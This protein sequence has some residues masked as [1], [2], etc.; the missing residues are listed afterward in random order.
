MATRSQLDSSTLK[1]LSP[2]AWIWDGGIGYRRDGRGDGG[3][4]YIKYRAPAPGTYSAQAVV[5]TRQI[6]ER[7]PNCK[8]KSQ[9][10]GVLMAR[11]AAIFEGTYQARKKIEPTTLAG[12][13][14]RFLETKRHLRTIRKYR[15]QIGQYLIPHFGK[16][17]L[18]AITSRDCNDYYNRRLDTKAAVSTVNGEMACLKSLFSEAMRNG[19]TTAN[20]VKGIKLLNPNNIRD[21]ILSNEETA[22]LFVAAASFDDFVRPLFHILF[23]TGMRLGEA[24][25]LQWA[26]IQFDLERIIIRTSKS[27]EGRRIPLRPSL[28]GE[29]IAWRPRAD[30]PQWLFPNRDRK[31]APMAAVRKGWIRLC[32]A[33]EIENLRPHDLRHNFTSQLQ[34]AGVSDSIIMSITGHKTHVMLLRYSHANDEHKRKALGCLYEPQEQSAVGVT[35]LRR[36]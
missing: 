11:K 5:P 24:L 12:F 20:P 36:S 8:N 10:E 25:A 32:R 15:Q 1:K 16:T 28:A 21:R 27:G 2:G 34:A 18:E 33:A 13:A 30:S 23:H 4:W 19:L 17:P 26:D 29:L 22:R 35:R 6:K 7:L 3:S 14:P 31:D 9:A